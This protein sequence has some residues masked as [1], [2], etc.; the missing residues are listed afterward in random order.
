MTHELT[1]AIGIDSSD[2]FEKVSLFDPVS[3]KGTDFGADRIAVVEHS[4]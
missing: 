1:V 4:D 3:K 2:P